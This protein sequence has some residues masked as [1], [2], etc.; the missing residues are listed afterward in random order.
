MP[1]TI[2]E[3]RSGVHRNIITPFHR[4]YNIGADLRVTIIVIISRINPEIVLFRLERRTYFEVFLCFKFGIQNAQ[5][6]IHHGRKVESDNLP[7]S[8][9]IIVGG[10]NFY[11][12]LPPTY[13]R[14]GFK[15][16]RSESPP[17]LKKKKTI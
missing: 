11:A 4:N 13:Y 5:I 8:L 15:G 9:S 17:V 12:I 14:G 16:E 3:H 2:V 7:N 6:T 10:F 1:R